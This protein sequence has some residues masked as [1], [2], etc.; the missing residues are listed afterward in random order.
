[1]AEKATKKVRLCRPG[2]TLA[3]VR[4]PSGIA[5]IEL[6]QVRF[7]SKIRFIIIVIIIHIFIDKI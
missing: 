6:V 7:F 3:H 4:T 1:M 2:V 5:R